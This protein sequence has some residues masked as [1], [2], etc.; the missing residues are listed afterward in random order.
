M[1]VTAPRSQTDRPSAQIFQ[2]SASSSWPCF[3]SP[4]LCVQSHF[5]KRKKEG[6]SSS[7][8]LHRAFAAKGI[9]DFVS[10]DRADSHTNF[11]ILD[12]VIVILFLWRIPCLYAIWRKKRNNNYILSSSYASFFT[13]GSIVDFVSRNR[14]QI[15]QPSASS[16]W[17]CFNP[18]SLCVQS[19]FWKRKKE[20]NSSSIYLHRAFARK[21]L[22]ILYLEIEPTLA[23]IFQFSTL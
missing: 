20:G 14:A 13:K 2:P 22:L 4:S 11:S 19:H 23:Q 10:R 21:E 7:I 9:I 5:W 12:I 16:S 8:Y 17:L 15:F 6:N 3:N 1:P 18:P